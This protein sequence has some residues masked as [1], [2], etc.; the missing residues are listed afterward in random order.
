MQEGG[1]QT[2]TEPIV[3][4]KPPVEPAAPG[5]QPKVPT[6]PPA[7]PNQ[8]AESSPQPETIPETPVTESSSVPVALAPEEADIAESS[9]QPETIPETPVTESVISEQ[10]TQPTA[11][12]SI[13][14]GPVQSNHSVGNVVFIIVAGV[15]ASISVVVA[16]IVTN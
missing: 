15:I 14:A 11:K 4:V 7:V 12:E 13:K 3:D 1:K 2:A 10:P 5:M 9:P 6:P 8:N 16:Y